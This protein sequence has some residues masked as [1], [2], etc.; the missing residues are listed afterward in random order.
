MV[1]EKNESSGE[2]SVVDLVAARLDGSIG[3]GDLWEHSNLSQV[4]TRLIVVAFDGKYLR[5]KFYES[6]EECVF[7]HHSWAKSYPRLLRAGPGP[8]ENFINENSK[9]A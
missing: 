8:R 4:P 2:A 6:F 9:P 7:S 3:V 1:E 5:V